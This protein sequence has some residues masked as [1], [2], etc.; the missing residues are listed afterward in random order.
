MAYGKELDNT[1][2]THLSRMPPIGAKRT[3]G[4]QRLNG[5][6]WPKADIPNCAARRSTRAGRER[7]GNWS[8]RV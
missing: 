7:N 8:D 6:S 5:G 2:A 1:A 3:L 4:W